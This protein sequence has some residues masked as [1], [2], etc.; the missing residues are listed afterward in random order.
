MKRAPP[1]PHITWVDLAPPPAGTTWGDLSGAGRVRFTYSG[2]AAIF[3]ILR[4]LNAQPGRDRRRTT[5]L[6]PAFHCPTVVD[7]VLHAGF[8][9]RF[10][11]IDRDLRVVQDDLLRKLD[12]KVAAAIFI[13]YFG[14]AEDLRKLFQ[15]VR[16]AG[17]MVIED[18]S[19]SFISAGPLRLA[20]GDADVTTYSFW[21]LIPCFVGGGILPSDDSI[22]PS[23][24]RLSGPSASDSLARVRAMTSQLF[25]PQT[26]LLSDLTERLVGREHRTFVPKPTIRK[27]AAESYPYDETAAEWRMP[28]FARFILARANLQYVAD[29][30]RRNFTKFADVLIATGEMSPIYRRLDSDVCPWGFPVRIRKRQ[31]RDYLLHAKGVP[32]YTFGEVLHPLLCSRHATEASM[33]G[34]A[35]YLSESLLALSIHQGFAEAQVERFALSVNEFV[36]ALR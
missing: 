26:E 13:R 33:L 21:K 28:T 36:G 1:H 12:D 25:A 6:I 10:F 15:A 18:R 23:I 11:A 4:Q 3:Q 14:F 20:R 17:A 7:P 30:R 27:S 9:V 34:A 35:R 16:D 5:V 22:L 32:V 19:H 24:A 29:A 2:R 8:D 31:E